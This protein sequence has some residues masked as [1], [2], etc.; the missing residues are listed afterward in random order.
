MSGAHRLAI[1]E[2]DKN[3]KGKAY[4]DAVEEEMDDAADEG[5]EEE[6]EKKPAESKPEEG[7]EDLE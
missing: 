5:A 1:G 6:I 3:L 2:I 7:D 4:L